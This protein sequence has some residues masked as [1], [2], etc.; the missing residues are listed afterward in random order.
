MKLISI[1]NRTN[2]IQ[3]EINKEYLSP[4]I[5][6]NKYLKQLKNNYNM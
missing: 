2:K 3:V 1:T 4:K 5:K 6:I